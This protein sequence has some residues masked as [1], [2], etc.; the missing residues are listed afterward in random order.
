MIDR[1]YGQQRIVCDECERQHTKLYDSDDF[2]RMIDD[3]KEDGW[4]VKSGRG[5]WVHT[6]PKCAPTD[7]D[8]FEEV[9]L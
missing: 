3:A 8:D 4:L 9:D 5:E 1:E 7:D 2:R 6:C